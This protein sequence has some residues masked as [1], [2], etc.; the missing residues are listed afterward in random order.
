[1]KRGE[2]FGSIVE[3]DAQILLLAFAG[4]HDNVGRLLLAQIGK[5]NYL[6][7]DSP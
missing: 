6:A 2:E 4:I 1:L 7:H 5:L 3:I